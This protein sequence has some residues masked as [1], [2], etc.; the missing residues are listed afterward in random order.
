MLELLEEYQQKQSENTL[1]VFA[2]HPPV[3][4]EGILMNW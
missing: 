4:K 3:K 1:T 2:I